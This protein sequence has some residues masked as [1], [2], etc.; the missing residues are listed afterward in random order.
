[1]SPKYSWANQLSVIDP[2]SIEI[3]MNHV[4][5]VECID[6]K[7]TKVSKSLTSVSLTASLGGFPPK[8]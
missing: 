4:D 5:G 1:M 2:Q 7:V 6:I 3:C 8:S